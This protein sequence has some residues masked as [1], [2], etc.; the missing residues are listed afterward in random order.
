[1][2]ITSQALYC[3]YV[4]QKNSALVGENTGL[5]FSTQRLDLQRTGDLR[6]IHYTNH[7]FWEVEQNVRKF[8][9]KIWSAF[10]TLECL[11]GS[12]PFVL[13]VSQFISRDS[14][15]S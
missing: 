2:R 4:T 1:M 9:L 14:C 15:V 13:N 5:F 3:W 11:W 12:L 8:G 6:E 10:F 7:N